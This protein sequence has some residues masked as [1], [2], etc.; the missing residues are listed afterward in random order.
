MKGIQRM[1][2]SAISKSDRAARGG[3]QSVGHVLSML[4]HVV[5][6]REGATV[7]EFA[8][9]ANAPKTCLVGL[10]N[11]LVKEG[12][13]RREGSG[14]YVLGER[15]FALPARV[16]PGRD[17]AK[18][19]RPFLNRLAQTTGETV[20]LGLAADDADMAVYIDKVQTDN[21]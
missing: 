7:T 6:R 16:A 4:K 17:L 9:H 18:L 5:E 10:I 13:L 1:A 14:R 15:I 2:S 12:G 20:V 3:P 8:V 21:P 11:A 19:A